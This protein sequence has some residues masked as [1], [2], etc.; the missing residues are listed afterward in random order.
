MVLAF[1][2][3]VVMSTVVSSAETN[4]VIIVGTV[5]PQ[6]KADFSFRILGRLIARP[7]N[8]GEMLAAID[9]ATLALAVRSAA[10]ELSSDSAPLTNVSGTE[11]RKRTLL[12]T[13]TTTKA[14]FETA[15]QARDAALS[16]VVRA[17][18]SLTKAREQLGYAEL[19]A[20]FGGVVT[21]IGAEIGQVVSP[22][23]PVVTIAGT[24]IREAVVDVAD[25]LAGALRIG[26]PFVVSPQLDPSIHV[27]GIIRE[28]APQA[29]TATRTRRVRITLDNPPETFRLGTT[30]T[31]AIASGPARGFVLPSSAILRKETPRQSIRARA[32]PSGRHGRRQ[33]SPAPF[34]LRCIV[35]L[36][37]GR[38][39]Y[40]GCRI[41]LSPR[42]LG[43]RGLWL[44]SPDLRKIAV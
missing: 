31:T 42:V 32:L 33:R 43:T 20:D 14:T 21:A 10:A 5:Q 30:I 22:G 37:A 13:D 38:S 7:V 34:E 6:I 29:D 3:W 4:T 19:K 9:A 25:D 16:T 1:G 11:Y 24:E 41:E 8:E 2:K 28:I 36:G 40:E 12:A 27:E 17:Q 18:A 35:R 15:E 39:R 44:P 23:Q 26:S